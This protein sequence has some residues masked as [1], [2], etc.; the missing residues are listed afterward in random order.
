VQ[1][2]EPGAIHLHRVNWHHW[3]NQPQ[4]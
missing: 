4:H 3:L 2:S 1:I